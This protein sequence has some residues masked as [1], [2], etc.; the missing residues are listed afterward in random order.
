MSIK[1]Q[2]PAS[3]NYSFFEIVIYNTSFVSLSF[4]LSLSLS[5]LFTSKPAYIELKRVCCDIAF[6]TIYLSFQHIEI[7]LHDVN[8]NVPYVDACE[9][10][11]HVGIYTSPLFRTHYNAIRIREI[12]V[13]VLMRCFQNYQPTNYLRRIDSIETDKN[14]TLSKSICARYL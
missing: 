4:F 1:I 14:S 3:E 9:R 10:V 6:R 13:S 5:R 8:E 11:P 12:Y 2:S 7:L